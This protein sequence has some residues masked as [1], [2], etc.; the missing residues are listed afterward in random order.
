MEDEMTK[1]LPCP[2]CYSKDCKPVNV[3]EIS[4]NIGAIK[5]LCGSIS[6]RDDY[7]AGQVAGIE[8][9]IS[10]LEHRKLKMLELFEL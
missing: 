4:N 7:K 9:C 3:V 2:K 10:F 6:A 1:L 8:M 5:T